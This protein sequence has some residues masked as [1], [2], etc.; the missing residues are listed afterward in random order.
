MLLSKML[1]ELREVGIAIVGTWEINGKRGVTLGDPKKFFPHPTGPQYP[2]DC[3]K[4]K[5]PDLTPTEVSRIRFRFGI[6][7]G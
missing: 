5:D 7:E 3:T 2:V 6:A 4:T 1:P